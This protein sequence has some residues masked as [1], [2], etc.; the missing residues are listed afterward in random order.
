MQEHKG[1]DS[2][3]QYDPSHLGSLSQAVPIYHW[4]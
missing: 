4:A 3:C 2:S 1:R